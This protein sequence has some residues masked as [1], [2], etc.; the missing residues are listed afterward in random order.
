M[1]TMP[2]SRAISLPWLCGALLLSSCTIE[3][4]FLTP[5][6]IIAPPGA[7]VVEEPNGTEVIEPP[8]V[9]AMCQARAR[10]FRG[11]VQV[12]CV[13]IARTVAP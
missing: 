10:F 12:P 9:E 3:G 6:E 8:K 11:T 5:R 13:D 4:R 7:T 1:T 2:Q